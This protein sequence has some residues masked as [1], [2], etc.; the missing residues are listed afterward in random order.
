M[1]GALATYLHRVTDLL[2]VPVVAQQIVHLAEGRNT[3]VRQLRALIEQEPA[4]AA[5]VLKVANSSL[6]GSSRGVETLHDAIRLLGFRTVS[7][8][9][10]SAAFAGSFRRFG[11]PERMLWDHAVASAAIGVG[12]AGI[13]GVG[14]SRDRAFIVGLL[15]DVGKLVFSNIS[16][17]DYDLVAARVYNEGREDIDV[18]R[19]VFGFDHAQ[20]GAAVAGMWKLP[21]DFQLAILHHT[22]PT[23]IARE[24]P[25]VGQLA[26]IAHV[27]ASTCALLGI[28][29]RE[30]DVSLDLQASLGWR[31][32]GLTP[33][34][35]DPVIELAMRHVD[36]A[37]DQLAS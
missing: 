6:Y 16:P 15:H 27:A 13:Q 2:P 31:V 21:N 34:D 3:S 17:G 35:V 8:I 20:L 24:D 11:L 12:L 14:V 7:G 28:G 25:A 37:R 36:A 23:V 30:P 1:V 9:A 22:D 32:L 33:F 5:R 4:I 18:E 26:A 29:C 10:M 19:E